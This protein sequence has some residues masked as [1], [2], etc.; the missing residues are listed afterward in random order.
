MAGGTFH[1]PRNPRSRGNGSER[2][3]PLH[4]RSERRYDRMKQRLVT[5]YINR[6]LRRLAYFIVP[7]P[8]GVLDAKPFQNFGCRACDIRNQLPQTA[9]DWGGKR[10]QCRASIWG[11][12]S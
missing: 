2:V 6:L 5:N 3:A 8:V 9:M 4:P 12:M 11:L 1:R 10:S 7:G